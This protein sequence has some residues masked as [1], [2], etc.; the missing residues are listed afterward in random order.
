MQEFFHMGGYGFYIWSCYAASA[1]VF[2]GL[3][4][5]VKSQRSRLINQLQRQYR[6]EKRVAQ[7]SESQIDQNESN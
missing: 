7:K 6:Q 2:I 3:F 1:I 5:M 4:L